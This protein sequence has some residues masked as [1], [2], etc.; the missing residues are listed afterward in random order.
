MI[1]KLLNYFR[2][3]VTDNISYV[4]EDNSVKVINDIGEPVLS[5]V[6]CFKDNPKRFRVDAYHEHMKIASG[7]HR[8]AQLTDKKLNKVYTLGTTNI[9]SSGLV[10]M[11]GVLTEK[12][13]CYIVDTMLDY[14]TKRARRLSSIKQS[15]VKRDNSR[16]RKQ[17]TEVYNG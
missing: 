3:P 13:I 16:L 15:R 6:R 2:T 10:D 17:L 9:V 1:T 4:E 8:L 11:T 5:F 7:G 12:E 14:Y